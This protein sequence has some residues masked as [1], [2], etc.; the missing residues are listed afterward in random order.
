MD[1]SSTR[2]HIKVMK[3]KRTA[4]SCET[5]GDANCHHGSLHLPMAVNIKMAGIPNASE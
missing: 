5:D 4:L 2:T 3:R 1:V